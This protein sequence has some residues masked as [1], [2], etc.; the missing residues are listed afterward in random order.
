MNKKKLKHVKDLIVERKSSIENA[1]E[2]D[3]N[4]VASSLFRDK[5]FYNTVKSLF[6]DRYLSEM[7]N[8]FISDEKHSILS[9]LDTLLEKINKELGDA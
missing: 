7:K 4:F 5:D 3:Y 8:E 6:F 2:D 1:S 9:Q